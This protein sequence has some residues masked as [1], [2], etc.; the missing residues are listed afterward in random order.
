MR[1]E[2]SFLTKP[3]ALCTVAP[4]MK[5]IKTTYPPMRNFGGVVVVRCRWNSAKMTAG[6]Q[7]GMI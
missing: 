7:E 1:K 3:S 6:A 5:A 4:F 2:I